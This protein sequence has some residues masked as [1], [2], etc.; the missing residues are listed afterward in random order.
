VDEEVTTDPRECGSRR[1]TALH[2]RIRARVRAYNVRHSVSNDLQ[3]AFQDFQRYLLDQIPPLTASDAVETLMAQPPQ[4]LIKQIHGWTLEQSRHQ[5][6][7]QADFFFY[8][9]RKVYLIGAL[10]L[11]DRAA[12]DAYF[13]KVMP[14]VLEFLPAEER[15]LLRTNIAG[16]RE[17]LNLGMIG[18]GTVTVGHVEVGAAKTAP[19]GASGEA[20]GGMSD[21]VGRSARR[22]SLVVERLVKHLAIGGSPDAA[23]TPGSPQAPGSPQSGVAPQALAVPE[24]QLVS[25]AAAGSRSEDELEAYL[26]TIGTYTGS[27]STPEKLFQVLAADMPQW[28]VVV[29]ENVRQPGAIEAMHKIIALTSDGLESSKRYRQLVTEAV[30]QFNR[31]ALGPAV[32]MFELAARVVV[33]KKIDPSTVERVVAGAVQAISPEQLKRYAENK[34]KQAILRKALSFFPTLTKTSLFEQLRGEER[35]DRRRSLLG[36]IEAYGAEARVIALTELDAEL[37]RPPD[38]SDTYYLRNAIYL[39]HRIPRDDAGEASVDGNV[40]PDQE[41]DL[42]TKATARGQNIYVIKEAVIPLGLLKSDAAARVLTMRLAEFEAVLARRDASSYPIDEM[43]KVLDRIVSALGRIATPAALLTIARH[44]VRPN[45]PLGDTRARLSALAPHDLSFDEQTVNLLIAAIREDLPTKILGRILPSRQQSPLRLIDALS[46]TRSESVE[47]LFRELAEKFPDHEIGKAGAAA[48]Y[49]LTNAAS[50]AP[51]RT[52]TAPALSGDL[53]FFGLPSLLQSLADQQATGI[54]TITA[55]GTGRTAG[56]LL[57]LQ[58][59]FADAQVAQLRGVDALYQLLEV[60]ASGVFSFV[61]H[62]V[63]AAQPK[64][65]PL[66]IMGVLFEGIRRYDEHRQ[67]AI[68]VPDDLALRPTAVK[69]TPDPEETDPAMIRDVWVKASSGAQLSEWQ[70]QI[71]AD[72]YR[73][74]RLVAR[75]LEEGALQ[76]IDA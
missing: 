52:A 18:L 42:L 68:F 16:M 9:L 60:P 24:A 71:A 50:A 12:L 25:M 70:S 45:P 65:E 20:G 6:A 4:L 27:T 14:L 69:P 41:L 40:E 67:L 17:S 1:A 15:E 33:E 58:G 37:R 26:R 43:Q 23:Q 2:A 47:S 73:I 63:P 46:S 51:A 5:Q 28:D 76:P 72:I 74:R 35:P 75:W 8:A 32:S 3:T 30:E 48:L 55:H 54:I 34:A 49:N 39:L 62:P 31:G 21:L 61:S 7:S 36:L 38:E 22:L 53:E 64:T 29:P 11:V 56:K 19:A 10:K 59:K 44:G 13:D 57:M 66:D